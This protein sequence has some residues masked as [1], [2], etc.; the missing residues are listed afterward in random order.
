MEQRNV[1][2]KPHIGL[3]FAVRK[4]KH[5]VV[6]TNIKYGDS[7]N[8]MPRVMMSI[9]FNLAKGKTDS[10]KLFNINFYRKVKYRFVDENN[11]SYNILFS[12][13]PNEDNKRFSLDKVSITNNG[14][15][16]TDKYSKEA[17]I[18]NLINRIQCIDLYDMAIANNCF[19]EKHNCIPS[20]HINEFLFQLQKEINRAAMN[21]KIILLR[22]GDILKNSF[23]KGGKERKCPIT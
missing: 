8:N 20:K 9:L 1:L 15:P 18:R 2:S 19:M 10:F 21:N 14:L 12:F 16:I 13:K 3:V 11:N 7:I 4:P 22:K 17:I 23:R 6:K 5:P